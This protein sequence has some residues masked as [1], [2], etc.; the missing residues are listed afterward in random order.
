MFFSPNSSRIGNIKIVISITG[1]K[2]CGRHFSQNFWEKLN[3][4]RKVKEVHIHHSTFMK[5]TKLKF[6]SN[7]LGNLN[8]WRFIS[9]GFLMPFFSSSLWKSWKQ[10]ADEKCMI[11]VQSQPSRFENLFS[12]ISNSIILL[13]HCKFHR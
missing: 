10:L 2:S 13:L 12:L 9:T 5:T 11:L 3:L 6:R 4:R 8:F 1:H 7:I